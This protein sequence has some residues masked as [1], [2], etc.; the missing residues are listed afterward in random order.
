MLAMVALGRRDRDR[1]CQVAALWRDLDRKPDLAAAELAN[2][3]REMLQVG[4]VAV[5]G[6]RPRLE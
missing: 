3:A 5:V 6:S 2:A 1:R 4:L